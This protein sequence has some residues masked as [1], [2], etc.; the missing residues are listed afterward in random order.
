MNRTFTGWRGPTRIVFGN[1]TARTLP[2]EIATL[3]VK[4][5]LV[6]A[7][8]GR[9]ADAE[10]L[11]KKL[12]GK[13]AGV[14][15]TAKEHVPQEIAD[16][17]RAEVANKKADAVL[18][19]G[20]GSSIGLAKA[21]ALSSDV[22]VLALPTTYSG[23]EMTPI[24]GIT[25][26]A[27]KKTGR[28]ER[29][30]PALVVYDPELTFELPRD[31]TITSLWNAMAHAVE[32]LWT[33]SDRA[34][35]L[36]AEEALRLLASAT[37]RLAAKPDDRDARTDALEGAY[38]AGA[39]FADAGSGLHHKLCHLLGGTFGM[40]HAATHAAL[41]PHVVRFKRASA[42]DA[43]AAIARAL[44]VL[45]PVAGMEALAR[46]TGAP[47]SLAKLGLPKDALPRVAQA[48]SAFAIEP[49][50]EAAYA[51]APDREAARP[52]R[53]PEKLTMLSG[54][55]STLAS[56][57]LEGALPRNQNAPQRCPYGLYPE[58][59]N[60][61][62]FT[63][64]NVENSRLWTYR[65]RPSASEASYV[66][67][68]RSRFSRPLEEPIANRTRWKPLPIPSAPD[69]IDF[70]D[71]LATLGGGGDVENGP[72]YLV[73][74]YAANADMED[75]CFSTIDGDLLIVPQEGALDVRT[76]AGW[77]KVPVGSF[78][79]IPRAIKF[80]V[81]L[82]EGKGRGYILEV[83]GRRLRLPERGLIGSNG[84]A[85]ARHFEA[86]VA[87]YEDRRP[88]NGFEQ[89]HKHG[90]RLFTLKN[91]WSPWDVVAWHG[92]H[93]PFVYDLAFY[94]PMGSV[95]FD[96]PDPSI[97]TVLTSPL[98]DHGRAICDFVAFVG[99]WDVLEHSFRPPFAH[100]NAASEVNMVV[101]ATSV[102]GGYAPGCTF[103]SPLL[104]AHGVATKTYDAIANIPEDAKW[105]PKRIPDESL[106]A[107]FES[108][109]PFRGTAW[110]MKEAPIDDRFL[111][112][113]A[114]VKSY[115]DPKR[116]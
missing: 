91:A 25:S 19:I 55:G 114:G 64:K 99:R 35:M 115:F 93:V 70:L 112:Q 95:K 84:L 40:P 22:R 8:P 37:R 49:L 75:R 89:V 29:V 1:G 102:E 23:S 81:G 94:S 58:L 72:G 4:N 88:P 30:R 97:L 36:A 63:M 6:I 85:D 7:T 2:D 96:H 103:L 83:I 27:T 101:R 50:L 46:A 74:L 73:H 105:E 87:S 60:G 5:V 59:L 56:E 52:L 98:D 34:T 82:P 106:W 79:V 11:A 104:T 18:A 65:I 45:D 26:G 57:A 15:A 51:G 92:N 86:P 53:A 14:L 39:V 33:T 116:R 41:L 3:D 16:A 71:G 32:S 80:A 90:G 111:D 76:E 31:V 42:P 69:R 113:F 20:G 61:T 12:E 10:T 54:F 24:W 108:A 48:M 107:M 68:P 9:R 109:L 13:S 21:I 110:A 78:L 44:H 62:P 47:T 28:D 66:A 77:L 67:L 43:M 17:A 100:R 38:L